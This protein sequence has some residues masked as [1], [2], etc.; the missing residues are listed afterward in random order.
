M[1]SNLER[2]LTTLPSLPLITPLLGSG[3]MKPRLLPRLR[4]Q[5][6]NRELPW[7]AVSGTASRR[8]PAVAAAREWSRGHCAGRQSGPH[9]LAPHPL[10]RRIDRDLPVV[11]SRDSAPMGDADHGGPGQALAEEL[12]HVL[13]GRLVER[14]GGLVEE[15]PVRTVDE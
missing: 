15:Q 11:E 4:S 7:F 10:L 3:A 2:S 14:R 13:L 8:R 9:L 6:G 1:N 12:V 5:S